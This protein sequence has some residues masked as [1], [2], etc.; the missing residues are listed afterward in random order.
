MSHK[1]VNFEKYHAYTIIERNIREEDLWLSGQNW[2][3]AIEGWE[4]GGPA[5]TLFNDREPILCGGIVLMGWQRGE[6]WLLL[7]SLFYGHVLTSYKAVKR[8]F[9]DIVSR[10]TL[11]R[12]QALVNPK[13]EAAIRFIEHLGFEN[14]GLLRQFGPSGE[15]LYMYARIV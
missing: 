5:Y 1:L 3:E 9:A 8:G 14:E 6:A 13:H 2:E 7:S 12:V 10:E 4:K 11:R 15:D